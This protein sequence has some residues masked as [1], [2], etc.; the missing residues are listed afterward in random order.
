LWYVAL[1]RAA[2]EL[3]ITY[4]Q[5]MIDYTR[6]AVLQKPSRFL[7]EVPAALYEIWSLEDETETSE[8]LKIGET[9]DESSGFL[10]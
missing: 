7:L 9:E 2:D 5:I 10:N 8:P 3:Y 1:T 6:Q 4:P